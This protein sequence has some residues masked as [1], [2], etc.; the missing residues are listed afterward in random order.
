MMRSPKS[1][2]MV[3]NSQLDHSELSHI[4]TPH[5]LASNGFTH[6]THFSGVPADAAELLIELSYR[7]WPAVFLTC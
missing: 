1:G 4:D 2:M 7:P 6:S 5:G 3:E